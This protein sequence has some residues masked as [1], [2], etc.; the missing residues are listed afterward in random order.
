[1]VEG[2][3]MG[4][5]S[6][7]FRLVYAGAH[8]SRCKAKYGKGKRCLAAVQYRRGIEKLKD[9]LKSDGQHYMRQDFYSIIQAR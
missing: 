8:V 4:L 7:I 6:D 9:I 2:F 5:A 1:M 3:G